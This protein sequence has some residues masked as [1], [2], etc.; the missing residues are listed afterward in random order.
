MFRKLRNIRRVGIIATVFAGAVL[1]GASP[2]L[3][4]ANLKWGNFP[5]VS[6][7]DRISV[8]TTSDIVAVSEIRVCLESAPGITWWKGVKLLDWNNNDLALIFTENGNHGRTCTTSLLSDIKQL[9]LWKA[10]ALGVHT[11]MYTLSN[12]M[13]MQNAGAQVVFRWVQDT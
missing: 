12:S 6:S 7:E 13:L 8:T 5:A 2:A 11:H 1:A 4:A 3:A 10:K 9:E